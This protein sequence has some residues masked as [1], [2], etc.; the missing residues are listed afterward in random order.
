MG[1]EYTLLSRKQKEEIRELSLYEMSCQ[2]DLFDTS[3][4]DIADDI[5]QE[6]LFYDLTPEDVL[7]LCCEGIKSASYFMEQKDVDKCLS[8]NLKTYGS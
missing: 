1:T 4:P 2:F 6:I 3:Y 7:K 8:E 5:E